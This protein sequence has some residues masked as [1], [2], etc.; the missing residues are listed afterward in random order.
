MMTFLCVISPGLVKK[1]ISEGAVL[2]QQ[3]EDVTG[4]T[5]WLFDADSLS[6]DISDAVRRGDAFF[7]NSMS[8]AF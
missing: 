4:G 3:R 5:I 1:L 6:F 2:L 7:S 8:I